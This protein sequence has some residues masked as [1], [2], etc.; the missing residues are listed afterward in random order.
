MAS[1]HGPIACLALAL[2]AILL[3]PVTLTRIAWLGPHALLG[4]RRRTSNG[5][6]ALVTGGRAQK[7]IYVT[8]ALARQRYRVIL[9]EERGWGY[10]TMAGS[11]RVW[12]S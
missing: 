3:T 9:A 11:Q 12:W 1:A 2:F 6:V 10:V 5:K 8:R 4:S 7:A